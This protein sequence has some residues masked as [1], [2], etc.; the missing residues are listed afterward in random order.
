MLVA[1]EATLRFNMANRKPDPLLW[2]LVNECKL[3]PV[4]HSL[5]PPL[6]R[7]PQD[8]EELRNANPELAK[9]RFSTES[10]ATFIAA[11]TLAFM[12]LVRIGIRQPSNQLWAE[13]VRQLPS[14]D[15]ESVYAWWELGKQQ[16]CDQY[17][18]IAEVVLGHVL[19][20]ADIKKTN[21]EAMRRIRYPFIKSVWQLF[22]KAPNKSMNSKQN[23]QNSAKSPPNK[24]H[25][26]HSV[27]NKWKKT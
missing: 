16:I 18:D 2:W 25:A 10:Q 15:E 24:K 19:V 13:S 12:V 11:S 21:G 1:L 5:F 4:I 22:S 6:E 9:T 14:L 3:W 23:A 17:P 27:L 7:A 20:G 26:E 8:I